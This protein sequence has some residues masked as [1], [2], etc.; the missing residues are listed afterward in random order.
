MA[1]TN[2]P[3][4]ATYGENGTGKLFIAT[5]YDGAVFDTTEDKTKQAIST[6]AGL[7]WSDVGYFENFE[8]TIKEWD[9]RSIKTDYCGAGEI[10][11]KTTRRT[12]FKADVQ[13]ILEM[14][15]LAQILWEQVI[16]GDNNEQIINIKAKSATKPAFAFKFE[17]CPRDGKRNVYY[18]VKT[19][20]TGD[21]AIPFNN[22]MNTDFS[23]TTLEF[24]GADG[25]NFFI[26]KGISA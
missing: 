26:Q 7:T 12:G 21:V 18:F 4:N 5:N 14:S 24:E 19:R 25:G 11:S 8:I 15:N 20:L 22:L 23:G 6:L 1:V 9:T 16:T 13:E 17:S 10:M 3:E 2:L